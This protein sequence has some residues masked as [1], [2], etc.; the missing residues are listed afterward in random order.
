LLCIWAIKLNKICLLG[1]LLHAHFIVYLK[2]LLCFNLWNLEIYIFCFPWKIV[3][4]NMWA[5]LA[6]FDLH[7]NLNFVLVYGLKTTEK[8][9]CHAMCL[10]M[11]LFNWLNWTTAMGSFGLFTINWNIWYSELLIEIL[12]ICH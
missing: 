8:L 1:D 6:I 12:W 11:G 7:L 10:S 3:M 2:L 4:T 9:T 5:I